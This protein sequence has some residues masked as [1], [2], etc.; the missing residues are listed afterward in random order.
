MGCLAAISTSSCRAGVAVA[1]PIR[2]EPIE[3]LVGV[4]V[5]RRKA[6]LSIAILHDECVMNDG[7]VALVVDLDLDGTVRG[8]PV[9]AKLIIITGNLAKEAKS[10]IMNRIDALDSDKEDEEEEREA[11]S[12]DEHSAVIKIRKHQRH[13]QRKSERYTSSSYVGTFYSHNP[14]HA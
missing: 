6:S 12:I 8:S 4:D 1:I 9:V 3:S 13:P 2:L 7:D 11:E 10:F 5:G 14:N